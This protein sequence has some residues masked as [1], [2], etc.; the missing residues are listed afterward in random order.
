MITVVTLAD[1][2]Y[3]MPLA[4]MV[5][6]LLDHLSPKRSVRVLVVDG[7][8]GDSEK[9]LLRASWEDSPG[10]PRARIEFVPPAYGGSTDLPVWGRLSVLTYSRISAA[11]YVPDDCK[12]LIVL[13]SDVLVLTDIGRLFDIDLGG[14]VVAAAQDP[15][16]PLVS[17]LDGLSRYAKL[18]LTPECKYFNAGVMVAD[19]GKWR[20]ERVAERAFDFV[21]RHWQSLHHYDQDCL[22]AVLAGH[23]KELDPRWQWHPR[24]RFSLGLPSGGDPWIV[25]FSGSLKPWL[26][27][28]STAADARFYEILNH[29]AWKG[30]QPPT[31]VQALAY[32]AYDS[33][34]RRVL[35]P[36]E[37][38]AVAWRRRFQERR[39][40]SP[41]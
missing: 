34:L 1:A 40:V 36:I 8:I 17:S 9:R 31:G 35:Y 22:N 18:G 2:A 32:R 29:T 6:S 12:R 14:A 15:Y 39:R 26:Y 19:T 27:Q 3:A 7:G 23:W 33:P 37:K 28:A 5:R 11:A 25:H 38:H 16:I 30:W 20:R 24:T 10:W 13:D 4:V 41:V 21:A